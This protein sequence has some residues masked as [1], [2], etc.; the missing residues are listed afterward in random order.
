MRTS[1]TSSLKIA[2]VFILLLSS[3]SYAAADEEVTAITTKS[4][5]RQVMTL[6]EN[7][8][9]VPTVVEIPFAGIQ[10]ERDDVYL[11]DVNTETRLQT[12]WE[13]RYEVIPT[14]FTVLNSDGRRL[15]NLSD[16]QLITSE[17][18]SID[19]NGTGSVE[20]TLLAES[21]MTTDSLT[22]SVA[23]N[24][25]SPR[26]IA[27]TTKRPDG[28]TQVVVN[29]TSLGGLSIAYP[30]V[31]TNNFRI[32]LE[33]DQPLGITEINFTEQSNRRIETKALRFLA[34]PGQGYRVFFDPDLPVADVVGQR[35]N[36][37]SD[38]GVVSLVPGQRTQN[39][40]YRNADRDGDGVID[41]LDNC[42]DVS[43]SDQADID[44]SWVGD[45]CEDFDRDGVYNN[46]D[47]C[48]NQPNPNQLDEDGDGSGDVCDDIESRLTEKFAWILWVGIGLAGLTLAI[49]FLIVARRDPNLVEVNSDDHKG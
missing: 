14:N 2:T 32:T 11:E 10:T 39:S 48:S 27:I 9:V 47:N 13:T 30:E 17:N 19:E 12:F 21:L 37:S 18:F 31:T 28:S 46:V 22:L 23:K 26:S 49:L 38:A 36:L 16:R 24:V 45:A 4:V 25:R 41:E 5:F 7:K 8:L 29:K 3:G 35:A 33:Y 20:L 42:L 34:Q 1:F 44:R 6:P 40:L 15:S 43:N